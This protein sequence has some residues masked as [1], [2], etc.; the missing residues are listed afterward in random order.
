MGSFADHSTRAMPPPRL[1]S[2]HEEGRRKANPLLASLGSEPTCLAA[3]VTK[4]RPT[5]VWQHIK[6]VYHHV[7]VLER[8]VWYP[9]QPGV[10][11]A[12]ISREIQI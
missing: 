10:S 1:R 9:L 12:K 6:A 2:R 4:D 8:C 3:S 7:S 11:N 5:Q